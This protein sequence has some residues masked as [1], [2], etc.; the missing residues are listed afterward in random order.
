MVKQGEY[1]IN[2]PIDEINYIVSEGNYLL[3]YTDQQ[4]Y[5]SRSTIKQI[6]EDISDSTFAQVHRAYVVNKSKIEKYNQKCLVIKN[7][8]IPISKSYMENAERL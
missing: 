1:N 6:L 7:T 4:V 3:F 8:K 5:K 2:L